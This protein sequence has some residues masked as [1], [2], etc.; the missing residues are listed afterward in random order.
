[1]DPDRACQWQI[2]FASRKENVDLFYGAAGSFGTFGVITAFEIQLIDAKPFVEMTN[3]PVHS[4]LN[5]IEQTKVATGDPSNDYVDAI[6]FDKSQ[7][8]IIT[9]RLT[10]A[11]CRII[12]TQRFSRAE[13]PWFYLYVEKILNLSFRYD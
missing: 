6:K 8:V 1:M 7:G 9:G 2:A 4:L 3:L 11:L 13:D 10:N 5:A 12:K